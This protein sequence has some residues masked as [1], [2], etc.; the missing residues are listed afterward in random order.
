M[1]TL[2]KIPSNNQVPGADSVKPHAWNGGELDNEASW[3]GL[4]FKFVNLVNKMGSIEPGERG[5]IEDAI[6]VLKQLKAS[7]DA[8]EEDE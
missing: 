6:S 5:S 2:C 4:K 1:S 3:S 8:A 7:F